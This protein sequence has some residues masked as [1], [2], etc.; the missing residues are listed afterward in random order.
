MASNETDFDPAAHLEKYGGGTAVAEP[1]A[2]DPAAH[3]AKYGG[4]VPAF[5]PAEHLAKYGSQAEDA[6]AATQQAMEALSGP[7]SIIGANLTTAALWPAMRQEQAMKD[8]LSDKSDAVLPSN[9]DGSNLTPLGST[10]MTSPAK[11]QLLDA[12]IDPTTN[13]QLL[14]QRSQE[15][16]KPLVNLP[17][18]EDDSLFGLGAGV[19][20]LEKNAE[21]L[22]TGNNLLIAGLLPG[23]GKI[24]QKAA[25]A[26][27]AM[28]M[29][30]GAIEGGKRAVKAYKEGDL[31]ET[32]K[33]LVDT[34]FGLGGAALA[35]GHA[36]DRTGFSMSEA[37]RKQFAESR[38]IIAKTPTEYLQAAVHDPKI[39]EHI[40]PDAQ[41]VIAAEL[42]RRQSSTPATDAAL[43]ESEAV[44][45]E[46]VPV[47]ETISP[48]PEPAPAPEPPPSTAGETLR[49]MF[50]ASRGD[51][52]GETPIP[53]YAA[54]NAE[55]AKNFGDN[56][57]KVSI[58]PKNAL[59][60]TE[61]AHDDDA[62]GA[63]LKNLLEKNGI[64]TSGLSIFK[65]DELPQA[66]NRNL[67]ELSKR[68]K[69]AGF[70]SV[71][72]NEYVY[73]G[74]ADTTTLILEK[75][76]LEPTSTASVEAP[77]SG[78]EPAPIA[79]QKEAA[80]A[81]R[82]SVVPIVHEPGGKVIV[83]EEPLPMKVASKTQEQLDAEAKSNAAKMKKREQAAA[84]RAGARRGLKA[85]PTVVQ[86]DAFDVTKH[87]ADLFEQAH[88]AQQDERAAILAEHHGAMGASNYELVSSIEELG[89]LPAQNTAEGLAAAGEIGRIL[90]STK[91]PRAN[92]M[93]LTSKQAKSLDGLREALNE[94][95][96]NFSTAH[97]MLDAYEKAMRNP[98]Q[99]HYGTTDVSAQFQLSP[100]ASH[101][102]ELKVGRGAIG[103]EIFRSLTDDDGT[104]PTRAQWEKAFA[105]THPELVEAGGDALE[106]A[107]LQS[108][109]AARMYDEAE[110]RKSMTDV[111]TQLLRY[112]PSSS[113][114]ARGIT[115]EAQA[116][117]GRQNMTPPPVRTEG[118][119]TNL[120]QMAE[121]ARI[122]QEEPQRIHELIDRLG[123][124]TRAPVTDIEIALLSRRAN[125]LANDFDKLHAAQV[126]AVKEGDVVEQKLL[127]EVERKT[128][129]ENAQ[130]M[131]VIRDATSATGKAL[132]A[133]KMRLAEDFTL[134][135]QRTL[136]ETAKGEKL[137]KKEAAQY[138][139]DAELHKKLG[140]EIAARETAQADAAEK[141]HRIS[142]LERLLA[143]AGKKPAEAAEKAR[144]P[145]DY[146]PPK[147]PVGEAF[148]A[149]SKARRDIL[150]KE[151]RELALGRAG[152]AV[153]PRILIKAV[154]YGGHL[155]A[156]GAVKFAQWSAQMKEDLGDT[157]KDADLRDIFEKAKATAKNLTSE[158]PRDIP[159]ERASTIEGAKKVTVESENRSELP[160]KLHPYARALA[161]Q[162]IDEGMTKMED[163]DAA[164][165]AA[166]KEVLPDIT[167]REAG[168]AWTG[169]GDWKPASTE[170]AAVT[171]ANV[172]GE[173]R[174]ALKLEGVRDLNEAR[175]NTG[176]GRQPPTAQARITEKEAARLEK[177]KGLKPVDPE[178]AHK[179]AIDTVKNRLRNEIEELDFALA[180]RKRII[181]DKSGVQY[182]AEAKDL[183]AKRDAKKAEY[184]SVFPKEPITVEEQLRRATIIAERNAEMWQKRLKDA[185]E[186]VFP[187]V[188][189]QQ[190][191]LNQRLQA[192]RDQ[193][194]AAAAE[195]SHLRDLDSAFAERKT[196]A[197]LDAAGARL[198]DIIKNGEKPRPGAKEGPVTAE[199]AAKKK[200]NALLKKIIAD[201]R[202]I[203]G[204]TDARR[205]EAIGRALD[206]EIAKVDHELKTGE[207]EAKRTGRGDTPE[208]EQKRAELASM[209]AMKA[210]IDKPRM[211]PAMRAL[212]AERARLT[213]AIADKTLR[214]AGG[215]YDPVAKPAKPVPLTSEEKAADAALDTLRAERAR[216]ELRFKQNR[217][218]YEQANRPRVAKILDGISS[219]SRL[220]LLAGF[221]VIGK[222]TSAAAEIS[223]AAPI[224]QAIGAGQSKLLPRAIREKAA[225][226]SQFSM[227]TEIKAVTETFRNLLKDAGDAFK[228]G[229]T[230]LDLLY[231]D[232][233][234]MPP[235]L[236]NYLG[237]LH[238]ALKSP[239]ARNAWVRYFEYGMKTEAKLSAARG[240]TFDPRDPMIQLRVGQEAYKRSAK[241]SIFNED[242]VV[243]KAYKVA[244]GYLGNAKNERGE[245]LLSAQVL[246]ALAETTMPIVKIPT[247]IVARILEY[248]FGTLMAPGRVG[249]AGLRGI[250]MEKKSGGGW[251]L[252]EGFRKGLEDLR[253]EEAD[254]IIRNLSRGSLG[255]VMLAIGFLLPDSIGGY[256]Q[257]GD[258]RE[259]DSVEYGGVRIFGQDVPRWMVHNPLL[260]QLQ[261]GA[262]LRRVADSRRRKRDVETK[263]YG[264]GVAAAYLGVAEEAPMVSEMLD[265][266][267]LLEQEGVGKL[268]GA[269]TGRFVPQLIK[270][271][272]RAADKDT[273]G[274]PITRNPQT[275]WE[276]FEM[277]WPY[278][279]QQV[280]EKHV[281]R[282]R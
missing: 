237:N 178:K 122:E 93:R 180:T 116:A 120:A 244:L 202:D 103:A 28:K 239:A 88:N 197:A 99:K 267:A 62:G 260:E 35:G 56:V 36:L 257:R 5:D 52:K 138:E 205:A 217:A 225:T 118:P 207:R 185:G 161:R 117:Q 23:A 140:E 275:Q 45:K 64:E 269:I 119:T 90:E 131:Q 101:I 133:V 38:E 110:G 124:D 32:G 100:G 108:K 241:P 82:A 111:V 83:P 79:P 271:A 194:R 69:D 201:A 92:R 169:Y 25:A 186:G 86:M 151:I 265:I 211:S 71:N 155:L 95:G 212:R 68:I 166:L 245:P 154:E 47:A 57:R 31:T 128:L 254:A 40:G 259:K 195:V 11:A 268:G 113:A 115:M 168:K 248:S 96:F 24:L 109:T 192:L 216:T 143:E 172:T 203:S 215:E 228:T 114:Q 188:D 174:A 44:M 2:F 49:K 198:Y 39:A 129:D 153:D 106:E 60:L 231:G 19:S 7:G 14:E 15:M 280:P 20:Q 73:G 171:L 218:I 214:I 85:T 152:I 251:S 84:V 12:G 196:Q 184:D 112:A 50:V 183:Q 46:A 43:A 149:K 3:L 76:A 51:Y 179:T 234:V 247:N 63:K 75:S 22:V 191:P 61:V 137:S 135:R 233:R 127:A 81:A 94:R 177:E 41:Q 158:A 59:D 13:E 159:A 156:E 16:N 77:P 105:G 27:F 89:K 29:G 263:G 187:T 70:D 266:A 104:P 250:L 132:Q 279:R 226:R 282:R 278:L 9:P 273:E 55:Y 175:Q 48:P 256:Y 145:R 74:G 242:N 42:Q 162:F 238:Y 258:R 58:Y 54:S 190:G 147:K 249:V 157:I 21:G 236:K 173:R 139:A 189:K 219:W 272:A 10:E 232:P 8:F 274:Q 163:I 200:R 141:A 30:E 97:E 181:R 277:N 165:Y 210:E 204:E 170:P 220:A 65:D 98:E 66:L 240:E 199:T 261:I 281:R 148:L 182:D 136:T 72:L 26:Y 221:K 125:A 91:T 276:R 235:E 167:E 107:W 222:L 37:E 229:N 1:P 53:F 160:R 34:G 262:T 126:K 213:R 121:A 33:A 264:A 253:P 243:T 270:E 87:E 176:Q 252:R 4:D 246:K 150:A 209:R 80:E 146:T 134:L 255:A 78:Q 123:K 164:V 223:T 193:A 6:L 67:P 230:D 142:E 130:L 206:S 144:I 102:D 208:N 18:P 227:N 224:E 17:K